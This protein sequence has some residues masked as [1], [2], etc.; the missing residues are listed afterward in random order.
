MVTEEVREGRGVVLYSS[1]FFLIN[2]ENLE[3]FSLGIFLSLK[4][5][6][7]LKNRRFSLEPGKIRKF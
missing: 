4:A 7:S 5:W 1:S 6:D 3:F 2:Q